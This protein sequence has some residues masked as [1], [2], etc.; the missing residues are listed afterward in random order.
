MRHDGRN[1]SGV[2]E[3]K[4]IQGGDNGMKWYRRAGAFL[5]AIVLVLTLTGCGKSVERV[6]TFE[7]RSMFVE[8]EKAQSWVIVYHRDT[9][10]MYAISYG[11]SNVGTFT[12]LLNADGTPMV[13]EED[14]N[15]EL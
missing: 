13:Y 1:F 15:G 7:S 3:S 6:S 14:N 9:R 12:V 8:I 11:V 10:V 4:R 5:V 2:D